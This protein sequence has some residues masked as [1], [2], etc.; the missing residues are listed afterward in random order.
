M[1]ARPTSTTR[2]QWRRG[3]VKPTGLVQLPKG[4][5]FLIVIVTGVL[6]RVQWAFYKKHLW[7]GWR[8]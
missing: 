7:V 1:T 3:S 8:Q 4:Q 2:M 5:A 6:A